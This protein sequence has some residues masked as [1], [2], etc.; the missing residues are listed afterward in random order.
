MLQNKIKVMNQKIEQKVK[1]NNKLWE[2]EIWR[3]ELLYASGKYF[4]DNKQKK[5]KWDNS[6]KTN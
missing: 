5:W 6:Q 2:T 3:T 4:R 1:K